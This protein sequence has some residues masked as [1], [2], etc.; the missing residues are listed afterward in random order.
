MATEAGGSTQSVIPEA[1]SAAT[2]ILDCIAEG[3]EDVSTYKM[4]LRFPSLRSGND[5]G[6]ETLRL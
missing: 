3:N 1:V 6:E 4:R 5:I 2:G